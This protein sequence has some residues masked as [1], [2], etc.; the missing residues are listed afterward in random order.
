MKVLTLLIAFT[1]AL[2]AGAPAARAAE[3]WLPE[4]DASKHV[5]LAPQLANHPSK[6]VTFSEDFE[7]KIN[8][9]AKKHGLSIYVIAT[10]QGDE[11]EGDRSRF[12]PNL[13]HTTLYGRWRVQPGFSEDRILM[14]LWVRFKEDPDHSSFA[15][16][17]GSFLHGYGIDRQRFFDPNGPVLSAKRQFMP[18]DPQ[19]AFLAVIKN[20]NDEVDSKIASGSSGSTSGGAG[21]LILVAGLAIIGFL[22]LVWFIR[23]L[24]AGGGSQSSGG[25]SGSSCSSS[26]CGASS[27][28]GGG[29]GGGGCGGGG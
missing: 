1:L 12:A 29:C 25:S 22:L 27:C 15:A 18:Q 23:W 3:T 8:E 13:L 5:Y 17:S 9:L 16:R 26:S 21:A 2:V 24:A 4:F 6:P 10:E 11:L 19:G 14:I 28:G 20:V 7:A